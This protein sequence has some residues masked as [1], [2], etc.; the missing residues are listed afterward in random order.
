MYALHA[1]SDTSKTVNSRRGSSRISGL[2]KFD[3]MSKKFD[4]MSFSSTRFDVELIEPFDRHSR[5][6]KKKPGGVGPP[7]NRWIC[8]PGG[9]F[10]KG[11]HCSHG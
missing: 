11:S 1:L 7:P 4:S 6:Q 8:S 5:P 2:L 10:Q 9:V 3:S